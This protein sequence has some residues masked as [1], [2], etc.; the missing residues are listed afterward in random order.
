MFEN[1]ITR[2]YSTHQALLFLCIYQL[3][4]VDLG[5]GLVEGGGGGETLLPYFG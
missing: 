3:A 5:E 2:E 4:V 1:M